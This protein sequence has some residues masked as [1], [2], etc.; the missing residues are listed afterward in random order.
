MVAAAA[1]LLPSSALGGSPVYVNCLPGGGGI[2]PAP[3]QAAQHPRNCD[4]QGEPE[5][6]ALLVVLRGA[7]WSHWGA[8]ATVASGREMN[9]HPGQGGPSSTPV[10]VRLYRIQ[11]GCHGARFYTRAAVSSQYRP[12]RLLAG[13]SSSGL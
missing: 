6:L 9:K 4:L 11:R 10:R 1:V 12:L 2:S 7:H 3:F 8:S 13:C 5:V